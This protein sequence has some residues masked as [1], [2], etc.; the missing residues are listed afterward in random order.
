MKGYILQIVLS[1]RLSWRKVRVLPNI[2]VNENDPF[3]RSKYKE[4][5][6]ISLSSG[7]YDNSNRY[8][9]LSCFKSGVFHCYSST[10]GTM[11]GFIFI[12]K[13]ME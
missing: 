11:Q 4:L 5:K 2:P 13:K 7:K 1:S 3:G 8:T 10:D 9:S 6:W 12:G